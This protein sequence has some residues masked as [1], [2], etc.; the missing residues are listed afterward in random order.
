[1]PDSVAVDEAAADLNPSAKLAYV[2][3]DNADSGL[4][5]DELAARSQIE[6]SSVWYSLEQ[7]TEADLIEKRPHSED[8]AGGRL[9]YRT[10]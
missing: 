2:I 7:L 9:V 4:T 3:L 1:M 10:R 8:R 6:K 5:A